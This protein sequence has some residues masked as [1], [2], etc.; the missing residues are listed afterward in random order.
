[1][2]LKHGLNKVS[3][4]RIWQGMIRRCYDSNNSAYHYYGGRGITVCPEWRD[5]YENFIEDM[6]PRPSPDLSLDRIDNEKG[7]SKENCRWA[8]GEQQALNRSKRKNTASQY[9][10]VVVFKSNKSKPWRAYVSFNRT[11][12]YLGCFKTEIEAAKAYDLKA[13]ELY[14][15]EAKLNF[16]KE[17]TK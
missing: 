9:R 10:G 15:K 2:N 6:G 17:D 11:A 16:K 1:M 12:F 5:S 8:T 14:G 3:E 7:Y 4:F 13:Y